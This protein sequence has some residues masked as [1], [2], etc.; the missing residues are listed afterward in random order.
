MTRWIAAV[1][2]L[3]LLNTALAQKEPP[4]TPPQQLPSDL[5]FIVTDPAGNIIRRSA[6]P[7]YTSPTPPPGFDQTL[8]PPLPPGF[9]PTL[10][11]PPLPPGYNPGQPVTMPSHINVVL[12]QQLPPAAEPRLVTRVYSVADLVVGHAAAA[13]PNQA[14]LSMLAEQND[15]L[16]MALASATAGPTG[17]QQNTALSDLADTIE[18]TFADEFEG[19]GSITLHQ[20]TKSLIVRQTEDM[21]LEIRDLLTQLR[22]VND[23]Q[24]KVTLKLAELIESSSPFAFAHNGQV[25]DEAAIQEFDELIASTDSES[26]TFTATL[27]NGEG[28]SMMGYGLPGTMTAVVTEDENEIRVLTEIPFAMSMGAMQRHEYRVLSGET[29]LTVFSVEDSGFIVLLTA[30]V[31]E[32]HDPEQHP[33]PGSELD[34][35]RREQTD[36]EPQ[37]SAA[38]TGEEWQARVIQLR[39]VSAEIV[40]DVIRQ[41]LA[42]RDEITTPEKEFVIVSDPVTNNIAINASPRYF[43]EIVALAE[44]LDVAPPQIMTQA[45]LVEAESLPEDFFNWAIDEF[46]GAIYNDPQSHE[47]LAVCFE[48]ATADQFIEA[49]REENVELTVHSQPQ[50]TAFDGQKSEIHVGQVMPIVD[51]VSFEGRDVPFVEEIFVGTV[52]SLVSTVDANNC[53]EM[54]IQATHREPVLESIE[55]EASGKLISPPNLS[56]TR[57]TTTLTVPQTST[58]VWPVRPAGHEETDG[59]TMLVILTAREVTESPAAE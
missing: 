36:G 54:Q 45:V 7:E 22:H 34:A 12:S 33:K 26:M 4:V 31:D 37:A 8:Q 56:C 18:S 14:L 19:R 53:I 23:T 43:N 39:N 32:S 46:D 38:P 3:M 10:V 35:P 20:D 48:P 44:R 42:C 29:L 47:P 27:Q 30:E 5:Q 11:P 1:C 13:D 50:V 51:T 21:H 16:A 57:A 17:A 24:I 2:C 25:L 52:V 28:Q 58:I 41:H 9:D 49:L 59:P 6:P 15:E 55:R 40:Y